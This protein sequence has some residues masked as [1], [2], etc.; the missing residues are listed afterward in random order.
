M[1][2]ARI[3]AKLE[4][5]GAQLGV[6]R[7]MQR[8]AS[9]GIDEPLLAGETTPEGLA[10][11]S[12]RGIRVE[13]FGGSGLQ[14]EC[15]PAFARWLEPRLR[16]ADLVHGHMFGAWWAGAQ[17]LPPGVPLVA[18][19]HNAIRWPSR[20]RDAELRMALARVD[21]F[22]AHGP[23]TNRYMLSR[24]LRPERIEPG[25]SA[26]G[27][28]AVAAVP[29][30]E[31]PRV[32]YAGRLHHEKG[33][34]LLLEALALTRSRPAAYVLGTGPM[35]SELRALSSRLGLEERVAFCGWQRRPGSWIRGAEACIVPSR[36][37]S[38]SQTAVLAMALGTPV[39]GAAVEGLPTTLGEGRGI[40]VEPDNP[41]DLAKAIDDAVE[42]RGAGDIEGARHY[43]ARFSAARV[44]EGLLA[45]YRSLIAERYAAVS[46]AS[47]GA[48]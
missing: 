22:F 19:E 9:L 28:H 16:D 3:I 43:A 44:A 31:R 4:P 14:Y 47:L 38:W 8:L 12:E 36:H 33:P 32:V 17:A 6:L 11:C 42:G 48:A 10:L 18:S 5:G 35:E 25:F 21:R 20:P 27:G 46:D 40:L 24:G 37:E 45:T 26:I 34:D 13:A 41:R 7:L 15:N 23:A 39:I 30:L 1:R 2:V 29:G